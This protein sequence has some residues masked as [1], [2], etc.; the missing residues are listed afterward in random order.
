[1]GEI[2]GSRRRVHVIQSRC[3]KIDQINIRCKISR[4]FRTFWARISLTTLHLLFRDELLRKLTGQMGR[5]GRNLEKLDVSTL[6]EGDRIQNSLAGPRMRHRGEMMAMIHLRMSLLGQAE[7][8]PN[9]MRP[10]SQMGG[11]LVSKRG[12]PKTT[13][14]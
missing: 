11:G 10:E 7:G 3:K 2:R 8:P 5:Q 12:R 4:H 1:M 6:N 9:K 14:A 13:R